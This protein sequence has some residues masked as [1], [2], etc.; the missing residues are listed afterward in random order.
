MENN[1]TNPT[2]IIDSIESTLNNSPS[3]ST[4]N[5]NFNTYENCYNTFHREPVIN[6][7]LTNSESISR[8]ISAEIEISDITPDTNTTTIPISDNSTNIASRTSTTSR[9]AVV[10]IP[11][12]S[13]QE[14]ISSRIQNVVNTIMNDTTISNLQPI[15]TGIS[16]T[17]IVTTSVNNIS[18]EN[19]DRGLTISQLNNNTEVFLYGKNDNEEKCAIC[20]EIYKENDICRKILK[21]GH[22]FHQ[23]CID[24][25]FSE[26]SVCPICNQNI[27]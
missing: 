6:E 4:I 9:T 26:H 27:V 18:N 22:I 24:T 13:S 16:M 23:G 5:L 1:T 8:N 14:D 12:N 10:P 7:N 3:G 25:W 2:E 11:L 21:C 17:P 20:D 19:G 15:G